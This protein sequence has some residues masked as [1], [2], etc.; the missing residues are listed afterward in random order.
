MEEKKKSIF[1]PATKKRESTPKK[2]HADVS[3]KDFGDLELNEIFK[4]IYEM[5]GKIREAFD[6][7]IQK[8]GISKED[9]FRFF[10]DPKNFSSQQIEKF[11]KDK[12]EL[13][14]KLVPIMGSKW[15]NARKTKSKKK[16]VKKRKGKTLGG[17]KGWISMR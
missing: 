6:N 2:T 10:E 12:D 11:E 4:K 16:L 8:S 17:R 7:V 13:E 14:K 1:D 5:D 3:W 9:L 15:K